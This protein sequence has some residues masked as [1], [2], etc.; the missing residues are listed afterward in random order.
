MVTMPVA[1]SEV[2]YQDA[3]NLLRAFEPTPDEVRAAAARLSEFYNDEHNRAM[4]T[5]EDA[6]S[7]EDVVE[8]YSESRE[9]EDRL[10]LLEQDGVLVGDA[11]FRNIDADSAEYAIMIGARNLQG[12][13]LGRKFTTMLHA[14]AFRGLGLER[15]YVTILP[16][17]RAS[18]RL[19]EQLGYGPDSSP[20]ARS[21]IDDES[22]VTLSV[23]RSAFEGQHR[24]MMD[25]A[26]FGTRK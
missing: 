8:Y 2:E 9:D 23:A 24:A 14:W 10:F 1:L 20:R 18:V 16:A 25:G 17:N 11:D 26:R 13:G 15:V 21:L 5:H 6:M 7:V 19:F 3:Q 4:L 22:D 12:R